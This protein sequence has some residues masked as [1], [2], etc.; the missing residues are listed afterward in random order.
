MSGQQAANQCWVCGTT[1]APG[2]AHC[3]ACGAA[4]PVHW[5]YHIL[6]VNKGIA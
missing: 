6:P 3:P 4:Q 2:A 5:E 1:T